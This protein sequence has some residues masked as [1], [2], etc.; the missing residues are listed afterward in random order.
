MFKKILIIFLNL[1]I[2]TGILFTCIGCSNK[3]DAEIQSDSVQIIDLNKN[4]NSTALWYQKIKNLPKSPNGINYIF[5]RLNT[6]NGLSNNTVHSIIQDSYGYLWIGTSDGLNRYDGYRFNVF[7]ND[8]NNSRSIVGNNIWTIYE[9]SNRN[10]WIGTDNGMSMYD[11]QS[12]QFIRFIQEP[13][14]PNSLSSNNVRSIIED[15]QGDIWVGT[16]GGGLNRYNRHQGDFTHYLFDI[17]KPGSLSDNYVRTI[18]QDSKGLI[19]VATSNGLNRFDPRTGRFIIFQRSNSVPNEISEYE[20]E[21]L[22]KGD[23]GYFWSGKPTPLDI[24]KTEDNPSLL[25]NNQIQV[26][27]EDNQ[28]QLWIG[29]AGGLD[30]L[31]INSGRF[32]HYETNSGDMESLSGNMVLSLFIDQNEKLWVG[33]SNGLNK[34]N[35][36]TGTFVQYPYN[37]SNPSD[38]HSLS[39]QIVNAIFQ[40]GSGAYWIGTTNGLNRFDLS[41]SFFVHNYHDPGKPTTLNGDMVWSFEEDSDIGFWVG[42]SVGIDRYD[43]RKGTF[44]P[45]PFRVN[46]N[47]Y[48]DTIQV[49]TI[50]KDNAAR[51]WAGTSNG[52]FQYDPA[53]KEYVLYNFS[54]AG[55]ADPELNLGQMIILD[56]VEQP[57]GYLWLGTYGSGLIHLD[58]ESGGMDT[59]VFNQDNPQSLS[60][61][62]VSTLLIDHAGNLFAGTRGGGL[63]RYLPERDAFKR[64]TG[65]PNNPTSLSENNVTDIYQSSAGDIWVATMSGLNR[66]ISDEDGFDILTTSDGLASDVI[67]GIL[68]DGQGVFW[69]ST[70]NGITR[71]NINNQEFHS[72]NFS[73]GLQA[74]EFNSGSAFSSIDGLLFF[75]GVNGFTVFDPS[76]LVENTYPAPVL[77]T[78]L[79]QSGKSIDQSGSIGV[80]QA[81]DLEWPK[82]Y[83]EFNASIL[84]YIQRENNLIQYRLSPLDDTWHSLNPYQTASYENLPGGEYTLWLTGANNDG[85]WSEASEVLKIN[86]TP[87]FWESSIFRIGGA[88]FAI[89][90]ILVAV[91]MRVKSVQHY[92]RVLESE[93]EERTIDIEKRRMV[94]EGLR[95]IL[96]R[97]NSD[98][99]IEESL[100]FVA[101][102]TNKLMHTRVAFI[103]EMDD[104]KKPEIIAFASVADNLSQK[105][106]SFDLLE[107]ELK[108]WAE[109]VA[110]SKDVFR[111]TVGRQM[112]KD[113]AE[114]Q[115]FFQVAPIY[116]MNKAL[117][118]LA[119]ME[120]GKFAIGEDDL[121]LLRSLADQAGLALE[122][123]ELRA[124]AEEIA[125]VAERNRIARDL[126]DAITQTL[127][128]ANLIAE[129]LPRV[130]K[131]DIQ[132][133]E[134]H[135]A[136][137]Q[138]LNRSALAEMRSL[139]LELRPSVIPDISLTDLFNQLAETMKNQIDAEISLNIQ[140]TVQLPDEIH[141][142]IYRI[143]QEA[144]TNIIKHA[145]A[146][147]IKIGFKSKQVRRKGHSYL[148]AELEIEDDGVGFET[149]KISGAHFGIHD[150]VERAECIGAEFEIF[151]TPGEGTIMKLI[152]KGRNPQNDGR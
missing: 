136:D 140:N 61:N 108:K 34:F 4:L 142:Q 52:L 93:V 102:Q 35:E 74:N 80:N 30:C 85:V 25:S 152:W 67:Y 22:Y 88:L 90:I 96:F 116:S 40:D 70:N 115:A 122:N 75:G 66:F 82:N 143:A 58:L 133:G 53:T 124:K 147:H 43:S 121:E 38:N 10:L 131:T 150:M 148:K 114:D 103:F 71:F 130:W 28:R 63:N 98:H 118:A 36:E 62:I 2:F 8:P 51:V 60:S 3:K 117:G 54:E 138:K 109:L 79:S 55:S 29:T 27:I 49:Y 17:E 78:N 84:N 104:R 135:L 141:L 119:V 1:I 31:N 132:K 57:K 65:D 24:E 68:E 112:D 13:G 81:I 97:L 45:Y 72:F 113:L 129:S 144:V 47:E 11:R 14:D 91:Q 26:I 20:L 7:R 56:M 110:E 42:T 44:T 120:T 50:Y 123:A 76:L 128:S 46:D 134:Q 94:A 73:Q 149:G 33:T 86:V 69:T 5:E 146:D 19:W 89:I 99:A 21:M 64:F 37:A 39:S 48:R 145:N 83:F 95:E 126:H 87:P 111:I 18:Y 92:T 127:F 32:E 101:C 9:D 139:L 151:S 41:T 15:T 100:D 6:E 23:S 107:S 59:Y 16:W 125:V 12:G 105:L 137:L 77:I 106:T